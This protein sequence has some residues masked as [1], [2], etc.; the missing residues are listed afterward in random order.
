M[1]LNVDFLY[2]CYYYATNNIIT[3]NTNITLLDKVRTYM[4]ELWSFSMIKKSKV[5]APVAT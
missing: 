3:T 5:N 2:S 1:T 4:I